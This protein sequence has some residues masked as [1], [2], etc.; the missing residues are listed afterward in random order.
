MSGETLDSIEN[1]SLNTCYG[2]FVVNYP[3]KIGLEV[4]NP[5]GLLFKSPDKLILDSS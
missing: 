4:Y 5:D 3:D 2:E 1:G